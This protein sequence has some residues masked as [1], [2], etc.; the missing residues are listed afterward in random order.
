MLHFGTSYTAVALDLAGHGESAS[1]RDTWTMEA[2][3]EDVACVLD[4]LDVKA[5]VLVGHSMGGP[6]AVEAAL[7]RPNRVIGVVGADSF[8][9]F[10][11]DPYDASEL[12]SDFEARM[13]DISQGMFDLESHPEQAVFAEA[14]AAQSMDVAVGARLAISEWGSTCFENS[15]RRLRVPVRTIQQKRDD[16][17]L[18]QLHQLAPRLPTFDVREIEDVGHFVM[19]DDPETFNRHLDECLAEIVNAT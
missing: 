7:S 16:D 18:G 5:A 19:L 13:K 17:G 12:R 1:D 10:Y 3:G 15:V 2:F 11:G 9:D 14:M 6:V 4:A 8:F